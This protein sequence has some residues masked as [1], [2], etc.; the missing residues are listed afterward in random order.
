MAQH[1]SVKGKKRTMYW[2]RLK[3]NPVN[4][5]KNCAGIKNWQK[6][7]ILP[8]VSVRDSVLAAAATKAHLVKA[9]RYFTVWNVNDAPNLMPLPTRTAFQVAYGKK[10]GKGGVIPTLTNLPCHQP[11]SWGHT[12][13]NKKVKKDL[14]KV[15]SKVIIQ[16]KAHDLKANNVKSHLDG[17][18][19]KWEGR[20]KTGRVGS[21]Q[22]WRAMMQG[23]PGVHNN[24]TMVKMPVS[25]I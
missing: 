1:A 18:R 10:G 2:E 20:L 13:Y 12:V 17:L 24:F 14:I 6:H 21:R 25:P 23:K 16:M 8:C 3:P 15:W 22:N 7:H 5:T 9:V 11:V 19:K 4:Y